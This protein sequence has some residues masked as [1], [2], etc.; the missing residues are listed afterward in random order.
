MPATYSA[1][2]ILLIKL[3]VLQLLLNW[4]M[5]SGVNHVVT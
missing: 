4:F 2:R 1:H 5:D 3:S